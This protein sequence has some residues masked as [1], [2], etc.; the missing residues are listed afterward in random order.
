MVG[1]FKLHWTLFL[2]AEGRSGALYLKIAGFFTVNKMRLDCLNSIECAQHESMEISEILNIKVH[3][4][5]SVSAFFLSCS[6]K[7]TKL[8]L[9]DMFVCLV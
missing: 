1:Y 8:E 3:S 4:A 7:R 6:S 2:R 5:N 9:R